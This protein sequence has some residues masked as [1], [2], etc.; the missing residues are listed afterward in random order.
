[1]PRRSIRRP[2]SATVPRMHTT[3]WMFAVVAALL[4]CAGCGASRPV[5]E[6][7]ADADALARAMMKAVDADAWQRTG[8]V[9]WG[10]GGRNDHL[11]DRRRMFS[12][13]RWSDYEVLVDLTRR[14]G[15]AF[16][17]GQEVT[18]EDAAE[19]V[20]DAHAKW[21]ND[22]FWLNPVVKAFDGGTQRQRVTLEDDDPRRAVMVAYASGGRTPGDAYLWIFGQDD[23]PE[24]WQMWTSNIPVGGVEASWERWEQL[25]TG[26]WI[27]TLHKTAIFDL[28]LT[29]VGGAAT[30]GDLV[31]GADPFAPLLAC[32]ETP[33]KCATA[34]PPG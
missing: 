25:A 2:R 15:R 12:R 8:A 9:Q 16:E 21:V 34:P 23:K 3:H 32:D 24:A 5:G 1:M 26:A 27:A 19:L 18:G 22:S 31:K 14:R 28:E 30:L 10:F 6:S 11:W 20:D 4:L 33:A 7:G 13:V 17:N 29:D